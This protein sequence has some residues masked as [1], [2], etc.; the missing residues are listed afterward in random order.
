MKNINTSKTNS[1]WFLLSLATIFISLLWFYLLTPRPENIQFIQPNLQIRNTASTINSYDPVE[2][3]YW[4]SFETKPLFFSLDR[5]KIRT[6]G[7]LESLMTNHGEWN[8]PSKNEIRCDNHNGFILKGTADTLKK[9]ASWYIAGATA[10]SNY[11]IVLEKDWTE[12]P[13]IFGIVLLILSL[14]TAVYS[15]IPVQNRT[16]RLF[17]TGLLASAFLLRFWIIFIV[18]PIETSIYSDMA[19]YFH[20]AQEISMGRYDINQLF[21]PIGFTLW[22]LMVRTIG[23]FELLAWTQAFFSWAIV[24]LIYLI[25]KK[26]FDRASAV[27]S[28]TIA[29]FHVPQAAMGAMHLAEN[30][31]AFLL[32]FILWRLSKTFNN[33]RL[34]NYFIIGFLLALAFYF[35]GNHAFFIPAFGFWLLFRERQNFKTGIYRTAI[36]ALGALVVTI[37]HLFW[38]NKHYHRPYLGP[39]AGAL[40]FV[41]GKCPSKD[42]VDSEGNRWMSPLFVITAEREF[43]QWSRPFTDQ[44]FF[45][46]EGFN[47]I[48]DNPAVLISSLRYIYYLF[49]ENHLW[50]IVYTPMRDIYLPWS[51]YFT[52]GLLP[53][54]LL[55]LIIVFKKREDPFNQSTFLLILTLFFTV[56]FFKSENR[57]RVPFDAMFILWAGQGY[58]WAYEK[59]K[60][61]VLSYQKKAIKN[62]P[63]KS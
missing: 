58:F 43:K 55:G 40:N 22:S 37:P 5:L 42:N 12:W 23:G 9:K 26:H 34:S 35:K 27:F 6:Q 4:L 45:W 46:K 61:V 25:A 41:E 28:L 53:F 3:L 33:Q 50:P 20:R 38:T 54:T 36:M 51:K 11:G 21:Q 49:F 39:T 1:S 14:S 30:I 47:C 62:Q 48:K 29:A 19:A 7:C 60:S 2:G 18:S 44:T 15:K 56:W 24:L 52:Y 17:V 8:L 31:Y 13:L 59:I 32:T 57:F 16:E 63:L 10:G